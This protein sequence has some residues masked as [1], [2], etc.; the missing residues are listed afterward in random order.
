M[1]FLTTRI[2]KIKKKVKIVFWQEQK[3]GLLEADKKKQE[4]WHGVEITEELFVD[5]R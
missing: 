1:S 4:N 3:P 2:E 5:D